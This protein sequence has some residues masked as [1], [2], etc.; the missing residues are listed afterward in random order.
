MHVSHREEYRP[1]GLLAYNRT[2]FTYMKRYHICVRAGTKA[3]SVAIPPT[4]ELTRE[5]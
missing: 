3:V 2:I 1:A 4:Q 5:Q